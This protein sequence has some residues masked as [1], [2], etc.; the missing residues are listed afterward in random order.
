MI[1][2]LVP[3]ISGIAGFFV[4]LNRRFT[5]FEKAMY[6]GFDKNLDSFKERCDLKYAPKGDIH[7]VELSLEG[8]KKDIEVILEVLKG[9][10]SHSA[11]SVS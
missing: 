8:I 5:S 3:V 1:S 2:I 4:Y 11:K 9:G 10:Q 6:L 7:T